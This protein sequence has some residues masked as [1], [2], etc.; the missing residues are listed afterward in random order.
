LQAALS[1]LGGTAAA[2]QRPASITLCFAILRALKRLTQGAQEVRGI[3]ANFLTKGTEQ[4][5]HWILAAESQENVDGR[6]LTEFQ[7]D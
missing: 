4:V 6:W 3:V 5:L 7:F 1:V 2:Q